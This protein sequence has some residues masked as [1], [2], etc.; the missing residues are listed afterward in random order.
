[1]KQ[2]RKEK[3]VFK[4]FFDDLGFTQIELSEKTKITQGNISR[5]LNSKNSLKMAAKYAKK[6]GLETLD[7]EGIEHGMYIKGTAKIN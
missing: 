1:M 2:D 5:D 3:T 4:N 7:F 6:L